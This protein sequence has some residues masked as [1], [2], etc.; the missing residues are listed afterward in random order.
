[1]RSCRSG[2]IEEERSGSRCGAIVG[3][4]QAEL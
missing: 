4:E 2:A 3:A 1:M